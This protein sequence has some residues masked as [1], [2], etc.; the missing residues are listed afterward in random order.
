MALRQLKEAETASSK[1]IAMRPQQ[2][3]R[4][5]ILA[6]PPLPLGSTDSKNFAKQL[7]LNTTYLRGL[8]PAGSQSLFTPRRYG[9]RLGVPCVCPHCEERPPRYIPAWNRWRW[10]SLHIATRH[11][12]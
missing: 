2:H 1:V 4:P 10:L 7:Q 5:T 9:N 12:K 8:L 6:K 3:P 11:T